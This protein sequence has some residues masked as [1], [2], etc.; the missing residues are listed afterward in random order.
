LSSL[1][2]VTFNALVDGAVH[3]VFSTEDAQA[4][5]PNSTK[6]D[7]TTLMLDSGVTVADCEICGM[8]RARHD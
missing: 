6:G 2:F 8:M 5:A 3:E 7:V 1:Q 4:M